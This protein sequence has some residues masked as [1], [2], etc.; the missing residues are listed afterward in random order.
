MLTKGALARAGG[1]LAATRRRETARATTVFVL[2]ALFFIIVFIA[3]PI[4]HSFQL[5]LTE[6]NGLAKVQPT[7]V[8][9][10][11][12]NALLHDSEFWYAFGNNV[13]IVVLSILIQLP[14]GMGLGFLFDTYGRKLN[15]FKIAYFVPYLMSSMAIGLLFRYA[16]DPNFGIIKFFT[17]LFGGRPLDLLGHP[18]RALYTVIGVVCWQYIPFYMVYFLAGYSSMPTDVYEAAII[19]GAKRGQYF[20]R[21]VLP[22]LRPTIKNACVLSLVGSLKYF[23]LIYVMTGGGPKYAT[24][25]VLHGATE[26][27]ATYMYRNAFTIR[28]MGYGSVV[29]MG[30]FIIVTVISA[31]TLFLM[32]R[33]EEAL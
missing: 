9:F 32:N 6:W 25:G 26:L 27:M 3:Y 23:D 5:S 8:G 24:S 17:T 7:N 21:I 15:F 4:V 29:A 1:T 19:D 18:S 14:I 11:N 16:V 28:K 31:V 30:L 22:L 13:R 12:W 2:P 33:K 10:A 20:W